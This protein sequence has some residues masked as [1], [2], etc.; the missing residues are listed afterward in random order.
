M[1]FHQQ[2]FLTWSWLFLLVV[3]KAA[4]S[5]FAF[6]TICCWIN[7][8]VLIHTSTHITYLML[9]A[10]FQK[11]QSKVSLTNALIEWKASCP[12]HSA[13]WHQFAVVW[14][15]CTHSEGKLYGVFPCKPLDTRNS[16]PHWI[17]KIMKD[18]SRLRSGFPT[19]HPPHAVLSRNILSNC[20][21]TIISFFSKFITVVNT[22]SFGAFCT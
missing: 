14:N 20:L 16:D 22:L 6:K 13:E 1:V 19:K 10:T 4:I 5:F 15:N 12:L 21:T 2:S 17:N 7:L 18:H 9:K 11:S 8:S 3:W